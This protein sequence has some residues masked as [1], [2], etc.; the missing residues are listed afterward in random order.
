M[1]TLCKQPR[2]FTLVEMIVATAVFAT[3]SLIITDL[4]LISNRAQRRAES[5]QA[6]QSDARVLLANITERVRS[7]EIDYAAYVGP[8]PKPADMLAIIDERGRSVVIRGSD[9]VFAN[10]VCPSELSTPCL[11]ISEDGGLTY[12]PMTSERIRLVGMQFY[13]DPPESPLEQDAGGFVYDIQPRV[14]FVLGLQGTTANA[15]ELGTTFIQTT[16][17]SRVLLR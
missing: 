2:G 4:F 16:V 15:A 7:G 1:N 10:T 5:S 3:A 14:T 11:E 17:S 6:I 13:I 12:Q 8:I 9:T